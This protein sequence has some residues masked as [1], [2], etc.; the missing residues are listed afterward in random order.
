MNITLVEKKQIDGITAFRIKID[1]SS[2][3]NTSRFEP[4]YDYLALHNRTLFGSY[5]YSLTPIFDATVRSFY[6][7][8]FFDQIDPE[9]LIRPSQDLRDINGVSKNVIYLGVHISEP[10]CEYYPEVGNVCTGDY[11]RYFD[12][13]EYYLGGLGCIGYNYTETY[14]YTGYG[15]TYEYKGEITLLDALLPS[16]SSNDYYTYT[17][18][19]T[20]SKTSSTSSRTTTSSSQTST[21]TSNDG[22]AGEITNKESNTSFA[23]QA[24]FNSMALFIT[25]ICMFILRRRKHFKEIRDDNK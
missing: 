23:N 21:R 10:R 11:S 12:S 1:N 5:G 6:G 3:S 9:T 19:D 25:P 24:K 14:I 13:E 20:S 8:G 7:G 17:T 4:R 15:G 2:S 16:A 18:T 22:G